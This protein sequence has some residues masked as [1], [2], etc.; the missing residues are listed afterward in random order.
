[1][2]FFD[3][4]AFLKVN[5]FRMQKRFSKDTYVEGQRSGID[6]GGDD[7]YRCGWGRVNGGKLELRRCDISPSKWPPWH[8][9]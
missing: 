5:A 8:A 1:M 2:H 3:K 9:V 4:S 6:G 7:N